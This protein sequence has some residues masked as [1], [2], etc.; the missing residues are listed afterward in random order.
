MIIPDPA[1]RLRNLNIYVA[2]RAFRQQLAMPDENRSYAILFDDSGLALWRA[3]GALSAD[4]LD[5]LI[6]L[7]E[8]GSEFP[9]F[10]TGATGAGSLS[11]DHSSA[12]CREMSRAG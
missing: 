3:Q 12:E 4:K 11:L 10:A 7:A 1:T 5:Q 9:V 2:K 8:L 6:A